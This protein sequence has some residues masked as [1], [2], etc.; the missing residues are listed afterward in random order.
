VVGGAGG[1]KAPKSNARARV[2]EKQAKPTKKAQSRDQKRRKRDNSAGRKR[3]EKCKFTINQKVTIEKKGI[4]RD[5]SRKGKK[6]QVHKQ[7]QEKKK[8]SAESVT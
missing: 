1:R 3:A 4:I 8:K 2:K 6:V 5:Q 7:T